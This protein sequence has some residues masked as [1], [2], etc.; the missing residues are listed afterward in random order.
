MENQEYKKVLEGI[1][2]QTSIT[3]YFNE[4]SNTDKL[5]TFFSDPN[6]KVAA[7][8]FV[9]A[10]NAHTAKSNKEI[11]NIF[12]QFYLDSII[13][14]AKS[15]DLK[16]LSA[17]NKY[18][19]SLGVK[20][21]KQTRSGTND[22][23]MDDII[24]DVILYIQKNKTFDASKGK[25]ENF[26]A[27]SI[28]RMI[29]TYW[30]RRKILVDSDEEAKLE[31]LAEENKSFFDEPVT[32]DLSMLDSDIKDF[33]KTIP[34][35]QI[36]ESLINYS[37]LSL[38]DTALKHPKS[39][40][41]LQVGGRNYYFLNDTNGFLLKHSYLHKAA[42][43]AER[44]YMKA[45]IEEM[46]KSNQ[47]NDPLHFVNQAL[48]SNTE[49]EQSRQ[50]LFGILGEEVI[51]TPNNKSSKINNS[52][53]KVH[54]KVGAVLVNEKG[55]IIGRSHRLI[56]GK[57]C[58]NTMFNIV[59]KD[60]EIDYSKTTLYVTLEPCSCRNPNKL[61]CAVWTILAGVK[62]VVI[63]MLDPNKDVEYNG[64]KLLLNAG[65]EV[66]FFHYDLSEQVIK[67][68]QEFINQQKDGKFENYTFPLE[69]KI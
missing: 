9:M 45:A 63:G 69:K 58:E 35:F 33:G 1:L 32:F 18:C 23:Y 20:Y 3:Y 27:S 64:V 67:S 37:D 14:K 47:E 55:E 59:L 56:T 43:M 39:V 53:K 40:P 66:D 24:N 2:E 61:P 4:K 26:F 57:H 52:E 34:K 28:K 30:K 31:L 48:L 46:E 13:T 22:F 41:V 65:I 5:V 15:N 49:Y 68:N 10:N 17:F 7:I 36:W 51:I 54:P 50:K 6:T 29:I 11:E 44:I 60:K 25:F 38:N 8:D 12:I 19:W 62:R 16:A 21:Y 42:S